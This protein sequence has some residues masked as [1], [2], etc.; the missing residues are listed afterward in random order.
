[1]SAVCGI[2]Y[3]AL[4]LFFFLFTANMIDICKGQT[5]AC[6]QCSQTEASQKTTEYR[7]KYNIYIIC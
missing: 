2:L 3:N 5:A 6:V 7:R 1:M 4:C